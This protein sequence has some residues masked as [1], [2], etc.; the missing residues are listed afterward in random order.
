MSN[1]SPPNMKD[2]LNPAHPDQTTDQERRIV[3]AITQE[4]LK[5]Q[6][7]KK[8]FAK[9]R[10]L[11][12]DYFK[13]SLENLESPR[14][15]HDSTQVILKELSDIFQTRIVEGEDNLEKVQKNLPAFVVTNHLGTYKLTAIKP[16]E[17]GISMPTEVIHPFPMFYAS[18]FPVAQKLGDNLY[19]A[20][21]PYEQPIR[22]V[23][24]AAGSIIVP[25]GEGVLQAAMDNTRQT[26]SR[27]ANG[28]FAIFPEGGTSGKRNN[29]GPYDLERFHTGPF[30][31]AAQLGVPIVPVAQY[32]NPDSGFELAVF[33]PIRL[34]KNTTKEQFAQVASETQ[35]QMQKW[36]NTR[37]GFTDQSSITAK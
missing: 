17:L 16:E 37:A 19:E 29:G 24:E 28:L 18:L 12:K 6:W 21:Y 4:M 5:T 10:D 32:F 8:T 36:L 11:M 14:I 27:Y 26:M 23:Q 31:I 9:A 33:P 13:A 2:T 25:A 1:T 34:A 30:V 3:S 15:I 35:Q 22:K 7:A 20:A